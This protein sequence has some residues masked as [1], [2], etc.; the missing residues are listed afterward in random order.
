M[1]SSQKVITREEQLQKLKDSYEE[2]KKENALLQAEGMGAESEGAAQILKPLA[3]GAIKAIDA[4][5]G[6]L[7]HT[8]P[9]S[10]YDI[11]NEGKPTAAIK[12]A[13]SLD[14][15][16][17]Y[18]QFGERAGLPIDFST[19]LM[20]D[21]VSG[22]ILTSAARAAASKLGGTVLNQLA[23]NQAKNVLQ[24]I[25]ERASPLSQGGRGSMQ[26]T[27]GDRV[28]DYSS[29]GLSIPVA[30]TRNAL[31]YVGS[32]LYQ[33][34]LVELDVAMTKRGKAPIS[35]D[36]LESGALGGWSEAK[37]KIDKLEKEAEAVAKTTLENAYTK[38][39]IRKELDASGNLVDVGGINLTDTTKPAKDLLESMKIET[40]LPDTV[41]AMGIRVPGRVE[42][43]LRPD[44]EAQ[45]KVIKDRIDWLE[46]HGRVS[47]AEA[48]KLNTDIYNTLSAR[49]FE[50]THGLPAATKIKKAFTEGNRNA[51]RADPISGEEIGKN[52]GAWGKLVTAK[53]AVEPI[54]NRSFINPTEYLNPSMVGKMAALGLGAGAAH[55]SPE[56][57][58]L[59]TG[60]PWMFKVAST[61]AVS[62]NIGYGLQRASKWGGPVFDATDAA[63]R[64]A[65]ANYLNKELKDE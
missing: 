25:E 28:K 52:M 58:A 30:P 51:L 50:E 29:L 32:R 22:S 1:A 13:T 14:P 35:G 38:N 2:L 36:L 7:T 10:I 65:G 46:S 57:I 53:K 15:T 12:W 49:A 18:Q 54:A 43:V 40:H 5:V 42:K 17:S 11:K 47:H 34:P 26:R 48:Q 62:G 21:A 41:D 24:K 37:K 27:I 60:L 63:L 59:L 4:P 56:N 39:P 64:S 20:L 9:Q 45:A 61:P 8:L 19:G 31:K 44:M 33:K 16:E 3:R 23:G 6:L 55:Q